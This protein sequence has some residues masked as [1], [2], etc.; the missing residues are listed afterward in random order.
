MSGC[1]GLERW[2]TCKHEIWNLKR[3]TIP[4]THRQIVQPGVTFQ[5]RFR[6]FSRH[7]SSSAMPTLQSAWGPGARQA[8][9]SDTQRTRRKTPFL[10][11]KSKKKEYVLYNMYYINMYIYILYNINI[12][13][14]ILTSNSK[15]ELKVCRERLNSLEQKSKELKW[16][17]SIFACCT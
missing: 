4:Q 17:E 2:T 13:I 5:C 12:Y 7:R 16:F 14:C 9:K 6:R 1:S 8:P 15:R 10:T 11:S 3:S